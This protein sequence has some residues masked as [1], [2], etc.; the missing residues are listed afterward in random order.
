MMGSRRSFLTGKRQA[1]VASEKREF[2]NS[3]RRSF[4][5][6]AAAGAML[7][8]SARAQPRSPNIILI[9]ADDLGYGDLSC[10]GSNIS[11][12]NLDRMAQEG[13]RFT[14][15]CSA[16]AVCSPSRAALM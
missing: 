4:L 1:F 9:F 2:L 7:A 13:M 16:S 8:V 3:D 6:T 14:H 10:Y 11:T 15:F 12:P 5:K